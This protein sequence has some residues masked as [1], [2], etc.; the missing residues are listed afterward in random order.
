MTDFAIDN[1]V[2]TSTEAAPEADVIKFT[3]GDEDTSN[4]VTYARLN[5]TE[6]A[7]QYDVYDKAKVGLES[8]QESLITS[9]EKLMVQQQSEDGVS[10]GDMTNNLKTAQ[11]ATNAASGYSQIISTATRINQTSTRAMTS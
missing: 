9:T 8:S 7:T 1:N 5:E 10:A 3:G 4:D 11:S 6:G 2:A